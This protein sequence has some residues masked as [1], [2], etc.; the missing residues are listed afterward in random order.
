LAIVD[1]PLDAARAP[2]VSQSMS[3]TID[4]DTER[5]IDKIVRYNYV[6]LVN[7]N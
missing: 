2:E 7:L 6:G 1:A 5:R 4:E 3:A